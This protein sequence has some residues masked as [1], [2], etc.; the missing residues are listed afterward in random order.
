M[1]TT[2]PRPASSRCNSDDTLPPDFDPDENP[3]LAAHYFGYGLREV[4]EVFW[5]LVRQGHRLPAEGIRNH[6]ALRE[7]PRDG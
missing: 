5:D 4:G 6:V 7:G 1:L 2:S 3:I